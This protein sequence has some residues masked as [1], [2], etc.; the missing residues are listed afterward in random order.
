MIYYI[1]TYPRFIFFQCYLS[2]HFADPTKTE[3]SVILDRARG[4]TCSTL[5][6]VTGGKHCAIGGLPTDFIVTSTLASQA[7]PA[8]GR[9]LG[10]S[11]AQQ[12]LVPDQIVFPADALSY[13]SVGDGSV[14]NAHFLASLNLAE[15]AKNRGIKVS[16]SEVMI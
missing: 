1:L 16:Y 2:R 4:Y 9:A 10:I 15:Y 7:P 14:N 12:L 3:E 5:D 11:L 6:P 13:V 8:V